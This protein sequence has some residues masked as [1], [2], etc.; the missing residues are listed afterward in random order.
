[1]AQTSASVT[2]RLAFVTGVAPV[3]VDHF[4]YLPEFFISKSFKPDESRFADCYVEAEIFNATKILEH[5]MKH[6]PEIF[7]KSAV[8]EM[9]PDFEEDDSWIYDYQDMSYED[10]ESKERC[11]SLDLSF[12]AIRLGTVIASNTVQNKSSFFAFEEV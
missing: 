9:S 5:Q 6:N 12:L 1:M 7:L 11:T 10:L 4:S 8:N 3:R 2:K